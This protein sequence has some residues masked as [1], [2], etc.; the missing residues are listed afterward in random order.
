MDRREFISKTLKHAAGLAVCT[1]LGNLGLASSKT[2]EQPQ[3][4][5]STATG[6]NYPSLVSR[7]LE[8]LG[9]IQQFIKQGYK[10]V[11]KPNIGWNRSP[12]MAANTHPLIVAELV[13]LAIDAGAAK[14][15]VFD[16]TCNEERQC[17]HRSG[18]KPAVEA[19]NLSNVS[20]DY[21]DDRKFISVPIPTG[22]SIQEW[23][24][25]K[26]AVEADCYINVPVAKHHGLTRLSLG[27]KN[28][29]GILGGNRGRIHHDIGQRL[30][31]LHTAFKPSLTIIDA[32]RLLMR[33]GP[34]GGS[35]D[36]V[37]VKDTL[38]ASVDI[39]A[40]DA[41][42]TTLFDLMPTDVYATVAAHAAGLG[43]MN[44]EKVKIVNA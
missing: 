16:R 9:G 39:V 44:L 8:P 15:S 5:L 42:A 19:L 10:V 37:K 12:E 41:Y 38:I 32:T 40:A 17:Y 30:A 21:I 31:D 11:I 18:I 1:S 27:L 14:V 33:N 6:N 4:I 24:I 2:P 23:D 7:V 26:E 3:S 35:L 13:K 28:I 36:D 25:Y 43:E 29:M 20:C 34:Q 22:K